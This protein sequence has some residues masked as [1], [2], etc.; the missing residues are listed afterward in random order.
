MEVVRRPDGA[1]AGNYHEGKDTSD[2]SRPEVDEAPDY[3]VGPPDR[4]YSAPPRETNWPAIFAALITLL[5]A[6]VGYSASILSDIKRDVKSVSDRQIADS[7]TYTAERAQIRRDIDEAKNRI[8]TVVLA[9]QYN[10]NGRLNYLEYKT[11]FKAP[12]ESLRPPSA[13][14]LQGE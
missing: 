10:V 5:I 6:L 3:R 4:R 2:M 11:G 9:F 14:N 12:P 7:S 1:H 8:D 13:P